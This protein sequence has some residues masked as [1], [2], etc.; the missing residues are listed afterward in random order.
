MAKG[1]GPGSKLS[2]QPSCGSWALRGSVGR[3]QTRPKFEGSRHKA[4]EAE[5]SYDCL[6]YT[7]DAADDVSTV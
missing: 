3:E 4:L 1:T 6:L 2:R 5:W 7:S